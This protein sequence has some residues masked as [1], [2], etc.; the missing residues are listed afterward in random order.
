M[1]T[2]RNGGPDSSK[3]AALSPDDERLLAFKP[4][5]MSEETKAAIAAHRARYVEARA[6]R[7]CDRKDP[8]FSDDFTAS[9]LLPLDGGQW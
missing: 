8:R 6:R 1:N 4:G 7:L 5:E 2:T 3:P 9:G